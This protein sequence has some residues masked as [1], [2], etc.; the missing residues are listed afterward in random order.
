MLT[1]C[2]NSCCPARDAFQL[3]AT[4]HH[5]PHWSADNQ[6]PPASQHPYDYEATMYKSCALEILQQAPRLYQGPT[7][8]STGL[9]PNKTRTIQ[10]IQ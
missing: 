6:T 1:Y 10:T 3:S 9:G 7:K 2:L 8:G 5:E 4:G